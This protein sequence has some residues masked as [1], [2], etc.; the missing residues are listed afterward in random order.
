[1]WKSTG[2][3]GNSHIE[4]CQACHSTDAISK[5]PQALKVVEY[6]KAGKNDSMASGCMNFAFVVFPHWVHIP[7]KVDADL[8]WSYGTSERR[9]DG[10]GYRNYMD[11]H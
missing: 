7:G 2:V 1:M 5:R 4:L 9:Q 3:A 11:V 8:P 10:G 6:V